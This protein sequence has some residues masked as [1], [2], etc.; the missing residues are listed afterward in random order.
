MNTVRTSM[1]WASPVNLA[2]NWY[3]SAPSTIRN[4]EFY[5]IELAKYWQLGSLPERLK[6]TPIT[7]AY[8]CT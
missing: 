4:A 7:F 1:L 3:V 8:F 2:E 6:T 5:A